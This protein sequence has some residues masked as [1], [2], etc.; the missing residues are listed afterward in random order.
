MIYRDKERIEKIVRSMNL[1][2]SARDARHT[3][4]KIHLFAICS[5]WLPLATAVLGDYDLAL[6][7]RLVKYQGCQA[8][9]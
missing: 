3:D 8:Q 1:K 5:Q 2:V 6:L 7:S 9:H 4:S